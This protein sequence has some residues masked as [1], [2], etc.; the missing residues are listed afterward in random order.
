MRPLRLLPAL[1]LAAALAAPADA[2]EHARHPVTKDAPRAAPTGDE[3]AIREAVEGFSRALAAGDSLRALGFLHPEVVVYEGGHAESLQ[4]YRS[5]HL[6]ADIAFLQAVKQET[7]RDRVVL[8]EDMA[9]YLSEY[10]SRGTYRGREID[11]RGTETMVLVP[12]PQGWKIRH[13]HWSSSR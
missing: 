7:T 2:Q 13:I 1:V 5:G 11:S 10:T 12:T 4:Q 3:A 6:R 9:L 8:S